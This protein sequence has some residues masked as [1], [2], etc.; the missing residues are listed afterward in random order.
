MKLVKKLTPK[1]ESQYLDSIELQNFRSH[2]NSTFKLSP[3][4]NV[5]LGESGNGK[6]D[7]IRSAR[8][9]AF[10]RPS[11]FRYKSWSAD[12][13][14]VTKVIFRKGSKSIS[15]L[16]ASKKINKYMVNDES[17]NALGTSVPIEVSNALGLSEINIQTQF[18]KFFLLQNTPGEVARKLNEVIGLDIIDESLSK[19]NSIVSIASSEVTKIQSDIDTNTEKLK[20]YKD[21]SEIEELV[22]ELDS[23]KIK[24]DDSINDAMRLESILEELDDISEELSL[25]PNIEKIEK[26]VSCIK[27][28]YQD[29]LNTD[30][31]EQ[32]LNVLVTNAGNTKSRLA[33]I[34]VLLE[35]EK[36][37]ILL[38]QLN[39]DCLEVNEQIERLDY[40]IKDLKVTQHKISKSNILLR[41][42]K[43]VNELIVMQEELNLYSEST[44]KLDTMIRQ[45]K[46]HAVRIKN[47]SSE[48]ST[49]E[50]KEKE[51]KKIMKICPTCGEKFK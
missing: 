27:S 31:E 7:V 38:K 41:S 13:S 23:L 33:K 25:L 8:L 34:D 26:E 22:N 16:R 50:S 49:F 45:A 2:S 6:S 43:D 47:T 12:E 4:M 9:I 40:L 32:R 51:L 29:W 1:V 37:L 10:N 18:E 39:N 20:Q 21:L 36:D 17:Y 48:I 24:Y 42:E 30:I 5:I 19:I 44:N 15:R 11:G 3:G 28:L 46:T 14:D 35:S